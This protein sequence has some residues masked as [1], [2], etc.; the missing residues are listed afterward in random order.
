MRR[1]PA[2]ALALSGCAAFL[3][4]SGALHPA[5]APVTDGSAPF[6]A[7]VYTATEVR[8]VSRLPDGVRP[9]LDAYV[10][11]FEVQTSAVRFWP[12]G[13]FARTPSYA[14]DTFYTEPPVPG[15]PA[16]ARGAGES[17]ARLVADYT[18][19]RASR[20]GSPSLQWGTYQVR[21]DTLEVRL[22]SVSPEAWP[23]AGSVGTV[24]APLADSAFTWTWR[25]P[26]RRGEVEVTAST[27]RFRPL[28]LVLDRS[29][30]PADGYRPG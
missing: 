28:A 21:D 7:G 5:S 27:Y 26:G 12:D 17:L 8:A 18:T 10:E 24:R 4:M 3:P 14:S 20:P 30:N 29:V 25:T 1:L 23:R 22:L 15:S 11:G 16:W 6:P 19:G 2:L 9:S 13:L